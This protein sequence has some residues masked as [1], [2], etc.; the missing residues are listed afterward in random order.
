M[1]LQTV[2]LD[3]RGGGEVELLF[4]CLGVTL[5]NALL[6]HSR[7]LGFHYIEKSAKQNK[8]RSVARLGLR[9]HYNC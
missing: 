6:A 2:A 5:C 4:L 3:L 7:E 1:H 9:Q 8:Q